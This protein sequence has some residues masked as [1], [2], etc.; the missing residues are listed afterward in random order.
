MSDLS[1]LDTYGLDQSSTT[2]APTPTAASPEQS[3]TMVFDY[4]QHLGA[5]YWPLPGQPTQQSSQIGLPRKAADGGE[6]EGGH[7]GLDIGA[8]IGTPIFAT[9][10]GYIRYADRVSPDGKNTGFGVAISITD[11]QK[12]W[13]SYAHLNEQSL[14]LWEERGWTT[15][16][17]EGGGVIRVNA[18]D[19]IGYTGETGN[20]M[21][22]TWP[23]VHYSINEGNKERALIDPAHFLNN[24][25]LEAHPL[26]Y[27]PE[28]VNETEDGHLHTDDVGDWRE[29]DTPLSPDVLQEI[30]DT[31]PGYI[32]LI[33]DPEVGRLLGWAIE[34]NV[35]KDLFREL[36]KSTDWFR[37]TDSNRRQNVTM[38]AE[39]PAT[40]ELRKR[41][42]IVEATRLAQAQGIQMNHSQIEQFVT[43]AMTNGWFD[44]ATGGTFT[45][46]GLY[47]LVEYASLGDNVTGQIDVTAEDVRDQARGFFVQL[48][49]EVAFDYAKKISKGELTMDSLK[50]LL[51]E[52]AKAQNPGFASQLDQGY[53]MGQ[54]FESRRQRIAGLLE[55]DSSQV[56]YMNDPRWG[57]VMRG[58]QNGQPMTFAE[59]DDYVRGLPSYET[60][61]QA[62]QDAYRTVDQL[63]KLMGVRR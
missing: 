46:Q 15:P 59:V 8:A 49:D 42:A 18:G 44:L 23:H 25:T 28:F 37:D 36:L 55:I 31:F 24:G 61:E 47:A 1:A 6:R 17:G 27:D 52:D 45:T 2:D 33:N 50:L 12:N 26:S 7:K 58:G 63:S 20:A 38:Q 4:N 22:G 34:N 9:T 3:K 35:D 21:G 62:Q 30:K 14:T 56:D 13:H 48:S 41:E 10:G 54:L 19:L 5:L 40:Y 43:D 32:S 51:R 11:D 16:R 60:T 57:S 53:T 39:D 29:W